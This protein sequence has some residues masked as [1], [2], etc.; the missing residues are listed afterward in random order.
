M[1]SV[2]SCKTT[3]RFSYFHVIA[4]GCKALYI[5]NPGKWHVMPPQSLHHLCILA[6]MRQTNALK[7]SEAAHMSRLYTRIQWKNYQTAD[8]IS[9]LLLSGI[10]T[11]LAMIGSGGQSN[12]RSKGSHAGLGIKRKDIIDMI[13]M[14]RLSTS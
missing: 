2:P 9:R 7:L 8:P 3:G 6:N 13:P 12:S 1:R 14:Q 11:P 4:L 10:K 5:Y